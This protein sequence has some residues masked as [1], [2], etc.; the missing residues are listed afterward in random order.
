MSYTIEELLKNAKNVAVI[1]CSGQ[2]HRTSHQIAQYLQ[3]NG[4]RIIPVN[5]EYDEILGETVYA[6]MQDIPDDIQID[7]ADIFRN[8]KYTAEM[9]DQVIDRSEST[10][11]K[12]AVWTQ[13]GVSSNEAK[14]KAQEAGLPYIENQ[15]MM[16]EHRKL[17]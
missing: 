13:L 7:I 6:T 4:Y 9:V 3:D 16:V 11:S 5:P 14:Q 15:C 10:G 8:K 1:G 12:I 2:T 17:S